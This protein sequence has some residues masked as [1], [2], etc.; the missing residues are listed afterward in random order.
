M[1]TMPAGSGGKFFS[2]RRR[3]LLLVS[4]ASLVI[5][6]LALWFSYQQSRREVQDLM[7]MQMSKTGQLMLAHAQ[8]GEDHLASLPTHID[9]V[10]GIRRRH[11]S[12]TLEYQVGRQDG[13]ILA[14]SDHAL[15]TPLTGKLGLST[16]VENGLPWR[17]LILETTD[18]RYRIQI[19][20]SIP[21]RDHE[22]LEIAAKTVLPLLLVFPLSLLAIYF[23]VRQGLKPLDELASEVARRSSDN[24]T[25]LTTDKA[26]PRE[27]MPLVAAI[28]QMLYRLRFSLESERRFTADAAHELRTPLAAARIQAQ[29]ALLSEEEDAHRHALSQTVAGLDR[30][31]RLVEQLLRLARLDPLAQLPQPQKI[32]LTELAQNVAVNVQNSMPQANIRLLP[33]ESEYFVQGD[34]DLLEVALRNL[35]DNAIR[36]SP[37][38]SEVSVFLR[39]DGRGVAL[40]VQDSGPGVSADE[41]PHLVER[42][43]RST[44]VTAE[45]SGLGLTIVSRIASLHGA[46]LQLSN[47]ENGG[48]EACLFWPCGVKG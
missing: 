40:G 15:S 32:D 17:S 3:L 16:V 26:I 14:R 28:N 47:R 12:L 7:D 34:A 4:V 25:P 45:G 23:S 44:S 1:D 27:T 13:S 48:F 46:E 22:A 20:E 37:E 19:A 33:A 18:R 39:G 38:N 41:L 8:Q 11:S 2:L 5:M 35:M 42:F 10:R 9:D 24:L 30:A 21:K 29:V 43:Y 6:V 31:T 36:Y